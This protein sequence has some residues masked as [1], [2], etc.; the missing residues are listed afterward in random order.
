[1]LTMPKPF[2]RLLVLGVMIL[3]FKVFVSQS[4]ANAHSQTKTPVQRAKMGYH[5]SFTRLK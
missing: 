1:M 2:P 4:M 3:A 5:G